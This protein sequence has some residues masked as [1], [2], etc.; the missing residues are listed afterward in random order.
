METSCYKLKEQIVL[1]FNTI[2]TTFT[3]LD[4]LI[5][6]NFIYSV[7]L[8]LQEV[9]E[10]T[11]TYN[12]T[13][14]I[15]TDNESNYTMDQIK[16][17]LMIK[18][19]FYKNESIKDISNRIL[20]EDVDGIIFRL[21]CDSIEELALSQDNEEME[22]L[23]IGLEKLL[24]ECKD[25]ELLFYEAAIE[26]GQLGNEWL[27]KANTLVSV[28][29]SSNKSVEDAVNEDAANEEAAKVIFIPE[30]KR[31]AKTRRV[32]FTKNDTKPLRK[33]KYGPNTRRQ[34]SR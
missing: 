25:N 24:S 9:T 22:E 12:S 31:F 7:I 30:K 23:Q 29:S 4:W 3:S 32:H 10:G 17:D 28:I 16:N 19:G 34:L 27:E 26:T 14:N 15:L 6:Q 21:L 11:I 33:T 1:K 2:C 13:D 5:F 18:Y 8:L 20:N